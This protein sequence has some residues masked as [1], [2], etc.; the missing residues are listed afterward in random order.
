VRDDDGRPIILYTGVRLDEGV[1]HPSI[2]L[3]S[4]EAD[5]QTWR[6]A[7]EPV[8][9]G[10]PPGIRPDAFRDPFVWRTERGWSMLVGAGT[11][12][13]R[14]AVLRYESRDLR[15][16]TYTGPFLTAEGL[17][18]AC[19]ELDVAE[20]DSSCW[21]CPQI[22]QLADGRT[23]LI[24]S[25]VDRS[26]IV[27]P[28][29]VVAVAGRVSGDAF[30]PHRA[31]R[32]GLG[33]DFYAPATLTLADGRALLFGWVP[34]D[35]PAADDARTWAGSLTLPRVVSVDAAGAPTI[36]IAEEVAGIGRPVADWRDIQVLDARPW[37]N[38]TPAHFQLALDL[39]L[40][41]AVAIRLDLCIQD[42][43][44][45]EIRFDAR[46]GRLT[47]TRIARVLV[48]GLTPHGMTVLPLST[49]RRL[50]LQIIVD[51]SV[52]EVVAEDRVTATVRLPS[53]AGKRSIS[54]TTF[55]GECRIVTARLRSLG[56]P[57]AQAAR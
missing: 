8:I 46:T 12:A 35:P 41:S 39:E 19:P 5:F 56:P 21:E 30:V 36:T 3:A 11:V 42:E 22:V 26:P 51:G 14:G 20:I 6:K 28:A 27:R 16:W 49:S 1:R 33:P 57:A 40:G 45:A 44:V 2:C 17:V 4:G 23:L 53:V 54:L 52:L 48:A 55:G 24:V 10:P 37:S 50:H 29:H 43:L 34:E 9:A 25:I 7:K 13:S 31:E 47:A 32:L 38:A 18:A 15:R